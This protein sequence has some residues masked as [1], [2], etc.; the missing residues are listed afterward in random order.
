MKARSLV[1]VCL[2]FLILLVA[3]C[4]QQSDCQS[5]NSSILPSPS[6]ES[7]A[8]YIKANPQAGGDLPYATYIYPKKKT[9]DA[10]N[11]EVAKMIKQPSYNGCIYHQFR[12]G[13]SILCPLYNE[14]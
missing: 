14:D 1:S 7:A 3:G 12:Q 11:Q 10:V 13:N 6:D 9:L 5:N 2:S 4:G 8:L